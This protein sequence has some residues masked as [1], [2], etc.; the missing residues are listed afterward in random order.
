MVTM[1][2]SE[3]GKILRRKR[4]EDNKCLICGAQDARTLKGRTTCQNCADK[5]KQ[6][7]FYRKADRKN[8]GLCVYCG[9]KEATVGMLS[10]QECRDKKRLYLEKYWTVGPSR[11]RDW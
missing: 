3:W 10:C 11:K 6:A 1:T 4:K 2:S 7:D 8:K 5:K 9:V